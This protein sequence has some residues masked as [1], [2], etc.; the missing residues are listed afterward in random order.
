MD[1]ANR[2]S[3]IIASLKVALLLLAFVL[4]SM[5][6]LSP[7]TPDP[8]PALP[9]TDLNLEQLLREQRLTRPR[10]AG[11]LDDGREV[12]LVGNT[13]ALTVDDPNTIA[14][15]AVESRVILSEEAELLLTADTGDFFTVQQFVA[16]EG[17]VH[18]ETTEG[19]QMETEAATFAM[20]T[21]H[22]TAPRAVVLTAPGL[23]IEAGAMEMIGREGA[24]LLNFTGGVRLQYEPGD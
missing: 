2:Y 7:R 14:M 12:T 22:L 6:F 19:Y 21:L 8:D 17:S 11:T 24:V 9:N 4:L 1:S 5:L 15:T 10:Y 13:A 16:L 18:A 3:T 20:D 23:L